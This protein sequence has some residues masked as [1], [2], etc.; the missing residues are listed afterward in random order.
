MKDTYRDVEVLLPGDK[1]ARIAELTHQ[2]T[3]LAEEIVKAAVATSLIDG[4][5][6]LTG[7]QVIMLMRDMAAEL[8][9]Q[10]KLAAL[11]RR[12]HW[13]AGWV[14]P[15]IVEECEEK[16]RAMGEDPEHIAGDPTIEEER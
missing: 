7:P 3:V 15:E 6:P 2:R 9:R 11:W 10:R 14:V 12:L 4:A 13:A 8:L 5:Q 16:L 1:D